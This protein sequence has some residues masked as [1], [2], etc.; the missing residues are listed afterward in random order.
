VLLLAACHGAGTFPEV[1]DPDARVVIRFLDRYQAHDLP[2]MMACL[3]DGAVFQDATGTMTKPQIERY[4]RNA[5]EK[6][7]DLRVTFGPPRRS[8]GAIL[9]PV[10]IESPVISRATWRFVLAHHKI[11][12]YSIRPGTP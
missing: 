4:L 10:R 3:D 5:L 2:G 7:P 1:E 6:H 8:D 9:V 12:S 11:Q